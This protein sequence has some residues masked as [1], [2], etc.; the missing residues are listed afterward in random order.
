MKPRKCISKEQNSCFVSL[1][2]V[3]IDNM[4]LWVLTCGMQLFSI[5]DILKKYPNLLNFENCLPNVG[6]FET[7]LFALSDRL[8]KSK[9]LG[10][11]VEH[12]SKALHHSAEAPQQPGVRSQPVS[13]PAVTGSPIE[14]RTI[15]LAL[16]GVGQGLAGGTF[17]GA[18][19]SSD[20][21][22]QGRA[23]ASWPGS[24]VERCFLWHVG[25]ADIWVQQAVW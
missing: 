21:L 20:S 8:Y 18:S 25:V 15:G 7:L 14:W 5:C 11:W 6:I 9:R 19:W 3:L 10:S 24:S 1:C 13:Q 23:P 12:Q 2:S 22:W 4:L 16:Y 17:L